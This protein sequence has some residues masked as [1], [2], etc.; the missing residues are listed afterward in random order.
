ML[1]RKYRLVGYEQQGD[2]TVAVLEYGGK[3]SETAAAAGHGGKGGGLEIVAAGNKG[4][5]RYSVTG[6]RPI[7]M[8]DNTRAEI[9]TSQGGRKTQPRK[10]G[11]ANK[12]YYF[13]KRTIKLLE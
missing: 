7:E 5:I 11:R 8:S 3:L 4:E 12:I 13:V 6:R 1:D 2:G 9:R 10:N